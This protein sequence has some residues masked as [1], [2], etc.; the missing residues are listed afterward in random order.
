MSRLV[1]T[2]GSL[3]F[4]P[5]PVD[6]LTDEEID[7]GGKKR[8]KGNRQGVLSRSIT[9]RSGKLQNIFLQFCKRLGKKPIRDFCQAVMYITSFGIFP[10][11]AIYLPP[12]R[13]RGMTGNRL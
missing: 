9:R 1:A 4:F 8:V 3:F 7:Y 6:D 2:D 13:T 11:G 5:K 12:F 10:A